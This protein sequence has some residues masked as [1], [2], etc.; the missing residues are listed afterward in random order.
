MKNKRRA[1]TVMRKPLLL[2]LLLLLL[3]LMLVVVVVLLLLLLLLLLLMC[4]VFIRPKAGH[5]CKKGK[6]GK[7]FWVKAATAAIKKSKDR[8]LLGLARKR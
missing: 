3:M 8:L 1:S 7:M 2:S 6:E 4:F 5:Q